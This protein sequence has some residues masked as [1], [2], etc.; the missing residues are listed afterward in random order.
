MCERQRV[1]EEADRAMSQND[2]VSLLHTHMPRCTISKCQISSCLVPFT[3]LRCFPYRLSDDEQRE[4]RTGL[5]KRSE[6]LGMVSIVSMSVFRCV[7]SE[8]I[9]ITASICNTKSKPH[10]LEK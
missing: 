2:V 8:Y 9:H 4:K 1:C 3:A 7:K 6:Q 10:L 5:G